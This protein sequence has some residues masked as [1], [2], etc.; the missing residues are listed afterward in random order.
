MDQLVAVSR[1]PATNVDPK[2]PAD[3]VIPMKALAEMLAKVAVDAR[4]ADIGLIKVPKHI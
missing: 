1:K 3:Q 2:I 4:R